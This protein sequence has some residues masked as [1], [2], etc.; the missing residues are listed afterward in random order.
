MSKVL[1]TG[2]AGFIGSHLCDALLARGDQVTAVDSYTTFYDKAVKLE[3]TESAVKAGADFIEADVT[4]HQAMHD[5]FAHARPEAVIHLAAWAG[6]RPSILAPA[7]YAH[8]NVC[9]TQNILDVCI[10]HGVDR[11]VIAS[12]SSVYGNNKKV[13]FAEADDVSN[14]ISPYAATKVATELLARTASNL[15]GLP[16]TIL[17]FFT[18]YGPRQRP[19][20][21]IRKFMA[22]IASGKPIPAY[23]DGSTSRDYTYCD[24]ICSGVLAALDRCGS[25]ETCRTYNLGGEHPVTLLDLIREIE[26]VMGRSADIQ[27]MPEQAGDVTRTWADISRARAELGYEPRT[28]LSAGLARQWGWLN[29]QPSRL[30][31]SSDVTAGLS[32]AAALPST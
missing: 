25:C 2:G 18:V 24:D 17:R 21:A 20:L 29:E 16:T 22:L 8:Q 4:N 31:V 10:K 27:W 13:P 11:V 9:G 26:Q 1:V 15:H 14:P 5:V 30:S 7:L 23:G 6:V 12:S 32:R 19:D 28:T 3:N